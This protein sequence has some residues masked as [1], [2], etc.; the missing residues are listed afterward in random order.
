MVL[1]IFLLWSQW[2]IMIVNDDMSPFS[3][4]VNFFFYAFVEISL[5]FN[6]FAGA[7]AHARGVAWL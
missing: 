7:T 2:N 1:L 6:T 3:N 5:F 4:I